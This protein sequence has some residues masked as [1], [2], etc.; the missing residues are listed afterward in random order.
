MTFDEYNKRM[1]EYQDKL[2][3]FRN[4]QLLW[5]DIYE[6]V[7]EFQT[8]YMKN[9][10]KEYEEKINCEA[11]RYIYDLLDYAVN[12]SC[13]GSSVVVV[14]TK[15][16]AD[17]IEKIIWEEIGDYL[18]DCEIYEEDGHWFIDCMFGGNYVPYWDG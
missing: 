12:F 1:N 15:E 9:V 11:R 17:E 8:E 18:L 10:L 4:D 3:M 16:I 6:E 5:K 13:T 2:S 7:G 14:K